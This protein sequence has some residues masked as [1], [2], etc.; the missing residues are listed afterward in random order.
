MNG[1]IQK[2]KEQLVLLVANK[3]VEERTTE[4]FSADH[5]YSAGSCAHPKVVKFDHFEIWNATLPPK[6]Q[7][8]YRIL[9]YPVLDDT[10][11]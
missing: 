1:W 2:R 6:F 11:S 3:S 10:K 8:F 9:A 5:F 7:E 4:N